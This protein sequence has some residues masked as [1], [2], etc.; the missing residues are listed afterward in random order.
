MKLFHGQMMTT[1]TLERDPTSPTI[2]QVGAGTTSV[3]MNRIDNGSRYFYAFGQ[4]Q[5]GTRSNVGVSGIN[6]SQSRV[7]NT[8]G[9][10]I[11]LCNGSDSSKMVVSSYYPF[12]LPYYFQ[13]S[14]SLGSVGLSKTV[15]GSGSYSRGIVI[16]NNGAG[17]YYSLGH[18]TVDGKPINFIQMKETIGQNSSDSLKRSDITK[19]IDRKKATIDTVNK[20]MVS[21]P[22]EKSE[23]SKVSFSEYSGVADSSAAVRLFAKKSNVS[24]TMGLVEDATG[25]ILATV[26]E[27][28]LSGNALSAYKISPY[29]LNPKGIQRKMVR[30]EVTLLTD[31]DNPELTLINQYTD[32][33]VLNDLSKATTPQELTLELANVITEYALEQN[34]P[35]PFNPS[36][37]IRYQLPN[38][39]HVTLKVYDMLGREVATLVD[40]VMEMGSYSVIF[41]GSKLSS[42][43]YIA[44]LIAKSGEGKSFVK[45]RKLVLMK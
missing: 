29:I 13:T 38:A 18:M 14:N 34:Y 15:S 21:E 10:D 27:S 1:N 31:I 39:G 45:V 12:T 4:N 8:T 19:R 9:Q 23:N 37:A 2:Y 40:G 33:N 20:V 17:I 35:N 30:V 28:K 41:D 11:Q 44:R 16:E 36:T 22:F 26:K 7:L 42:G 6:I 24:F 25:K 43:V 32:A 3:S 5:N